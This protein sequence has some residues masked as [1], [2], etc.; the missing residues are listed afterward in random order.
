MHSNYCATSSLFG[1]TIL[2]VESDIEAVFRSNDM[3]RKTFEKIYSSVGE[4]DMQSQD[5]LFKSKLL[6]PYYRSLR[7]IGLPTHC[8]RGRSFRGE[9]LS[10]LD[11]TGM[12]LR[13]CDFRGCDLSGALFLRCRM[14]NAD[15]R[16]ATLYHTV[17]TDAHL[18]KVDFRG[19]DLS[20]SSFNGAN[21]RSSKKDNDQKFSRKATRPKKVH[22]SKEQYIIDPDDYLEDLFEED[23]DSMYGVLRDCWAEAYQ[24]LAGLGT[25]ASEEDKTVRL[26]LIAG[27][28]CSGKTSIGR[29]FASRE[30]VNEDI[31]IIF[32]A[33]FINEVSRSAALNFAKGLGWYVDC[34]FMNTPLA[35]CLFNNASNGDLA[36]PSDVM[37]A[38]EDALVVPQVSEGFHQVTLL[39]Q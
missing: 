28:P 19:C 37:Y 14:T 15:L 27:L 34:V 1:V 4:W 8:V 7:D 18:Y 26:T 3:A 16:K 25:L 17:F 30:H 36:L 39:S 35:T 9:D 31:H 23:E 38:M 24:T 32:E 20:S 29:S 22:S 2:L 33:T 5:A 12:D 13:K 11:F 21:T 10:H 6:R